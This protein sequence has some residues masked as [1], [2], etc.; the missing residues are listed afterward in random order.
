[1]DATMPLLNKI[2]CLLV[3]ILSLPALVYASDNGESYFSTEGIENTRYQVT[4]LSLGKTHYSLGS[5]SGPGTLGEN[6]SAMALYTDVRMSG[7]WWF[8]AGYGRWADKTDY[9]CSPVDSSDCTRWH[10]KLS[11]WFMAP[12]WQVDFLQ[13]RLHAGIF[14]GV[15]YSSYQT[16]Y[17]NRSDDPSSM[18][19]LDL[20][21]N[22][23]R[24]F[25]V[26]YSYSTG[27]AE[28]LNGMDIEYSTGLFG[29]AA[30]F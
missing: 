3:F 6:S 15:T 7:K 16:T 19:I 27:S 11:S 25:S 13:K 24:T 14:V 12:G 28:E 23:S 29:L 1:M 5:D 17:G 10:K 8:R 20:G 18:L 22:I 4:A 21:L 30:R 9:Y 26:T 2:D